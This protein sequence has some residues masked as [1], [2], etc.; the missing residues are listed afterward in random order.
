MEGVAGAALWLLSDL[1][2]STT[3]EVVHV[4]AGFHM[5]G[6][7]SE[8]GGMRT[9][10]DD[11]ASRS[12]DVIIAGAGIAGRD[13]GAGPERGRA[14]ASSSID[15][16]PFDAQ[17][18]PTF[19][20]RASAISFAAFRQWRALGVGGALEPHAQRIEQILVTD[21]RAPGRGRR[22]GAGRPSCAS[23][24]PR[25][26]T[27]PDGEPLGYLLENRHIRAALA[28][29]GDGGRASTVLAPAAGR[30]QSTSAR[31]RRG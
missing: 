17:V 9:G 18:A 26:P 31:A 21:G 22:A 7:P 27:A 16:Q 29:A 25:S 13:A 14:E 28:A 3:G 10:D 19:D 4:D 30:A 1:G 20:G 5:M 2:R 24:P 8:D 6:L 11:A 12:V 23:T 15:P